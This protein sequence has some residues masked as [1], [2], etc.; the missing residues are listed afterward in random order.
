MTNFHDFRARDIDGQEKSLRDF[1]GQVCL[2]VNVASR[3]G[4]TPHY[5]GLQA[6]HQ[7][8]GE[9]GFAVLGFPCNQFGAQEPGSEAEIREFC[10][11]R[12]K[13]TFPMFAKLEVN[14]PKRAPLYAWLTAQPTLP[15]GPGDIAWN[16]AK[17]LIGKD[18]RVR[19]RFDPSTEPTGNEIR[20]AIAEALAE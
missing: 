1:E 14:G 11:T 3:C 2:V 6:L 5:Q 15:D 13:V 10:S 17:F 12:Y 4:L 7:R 8:Y 9:R 20:N 19:A 16:F 18:G